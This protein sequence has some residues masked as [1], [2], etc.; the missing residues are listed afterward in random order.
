MVDLPAPYA[1]LIQ[2]IDQHTIWHHDDIDD[3]L[4]YH[5]NR[6]EEVQLTLTLP[7]LLALWMD[8]HE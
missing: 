4:R 8:R 5:E 7:E 6:V 1:A 2:W 3:M